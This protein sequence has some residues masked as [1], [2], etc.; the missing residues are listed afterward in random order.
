MTQPPNGDEGQRPGAAD[1]AR[2]A[3]GAPPTWPEAAPQYPP[4][5]DPFATG[6]Q[7][8]IPPAPAAYPPQP[9]GAAYPPQTPGAAYPPQTPDAAYPPRPPDAAYPPPGFEA[10][11][12]ADPA[13][14]RRGLLITSIVLGLALLLCGGGGVGAWLY[15]TK[16]DRGQGADAPEAAVDEFLDAVYDK[17]DAERAAE[18]VCSHARDMTEITKKIDEVEAYAEKY[19]NTRFDW[20]DPKVD[21]QTEDRAKVSVKVTASTG[22]EREATLDLTFTVI[23]ESGWWVCEVGG[24]A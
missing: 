20:D 5:V 14:R 11:P 17:R 16:V 9:P 10:A 15:L 2:P 7:A 4:A 21:E 8:P 23:R 24:P 3:E 19:K 22:D 12:P 13:P 1:P 18:L 6:A